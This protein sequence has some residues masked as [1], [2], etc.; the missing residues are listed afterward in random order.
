[1]NGWTE[2]ILEAVAVGV[3]VGFYL[4][5][6]QHSVVAL[7]CYVTVQLK[8]VSALPDD[9]NLLVMYRQLFNVTAM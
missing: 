7:P 5:V 3:V 8:T 4:H 9:K 2:H 1:M 6:V